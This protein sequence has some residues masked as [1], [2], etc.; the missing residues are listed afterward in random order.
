MPNDEDNLGDLLLSEAVGAPSEPKP[1]AATELIA[2]PGCSRPNAPSRTSCLYCGAALPVNAGAA[3]LQ[4]PVL[5]PLEKWEHGYNNIRLPSAVI[6]SEDA[7]ADLSKMLKLG[8]S[9]L[10][11]ILASELPLPLARTSNFDEALLV[12]R[13]LAEAGVESV[14]FS[15]EE[16]GVTG[17]AIK[18]VRSVTVSDTGMD[19]Y[20]SPETSPVFI[21]WDDVALIVTG[22]VTTKRLEFKEQRTR[23]ENQIVES[24]EFFDDELVMDIH[25]Y[26]KGPV[27]RITSKTFDFSCLGTRKR[28]LAEENL[29]QLVELIQEHASSARV[30]SSYNSSLKLLEIVWP[31][32]RVNESG[33]WRRDWPGRFTLGGSAVVTNYD[34]FTKYSRLRF[35]VLDLRDEK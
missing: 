26:S 4:R 35:R 28:F 12:Q 31:A 16:L 34:Q 5:R 25:S 7:I 3:Q 22:R 18:R 33:G 23:A 29:K 24:S 10:G 27:Y 11:K 13:K 20:Q 1:F 30:D 6:L 14:V 17:D 15:D 9:D 21:A 2:C 8:A 19:A 32:E